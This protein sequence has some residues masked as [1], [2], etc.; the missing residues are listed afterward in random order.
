[1]QAYAAILTNIFGGAINKVPR[2]DCLRLCHCHKVIKQPIARKSVVPYFSAVFKA[3][4]TFSTCARV[5]KGMRC[6]L[7][8]SMKL[9][10]S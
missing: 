2:D 10:I 4:A 3:A 5:I 8:Y 6:A 7:V 9:P 1:M